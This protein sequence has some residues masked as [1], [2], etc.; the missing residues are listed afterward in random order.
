M[1]LARI[2]TKERI[3]WVVGVVLKLFNIL[4]MLGDG[5]A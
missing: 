3:Y 5:R 1:F 2:W 4:A